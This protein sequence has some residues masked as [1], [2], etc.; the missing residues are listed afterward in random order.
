MTVSQLDVDVCD[1][2]LP[3]EPGL[4]FNLAMFSAAVKEN[5][6][7]GAAAMPGTKTGIACCAPGTLSAA[8]KHAA[9]SLI[10][11]LA[12]CQR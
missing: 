2:R 11:R 6:A 1:R 10:D 8:M 5:F 12:Y 7:G 4:Y 3:G 9:A